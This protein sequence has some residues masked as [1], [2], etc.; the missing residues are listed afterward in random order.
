MAQVEPGDN[1]AEEQGQEHGRGLPAVHTQPI[2][3]A[4]IPDRQKA[5]GAKAA[6]SQKLLTSLHPDSIPLVSHVP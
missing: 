3:Q 6:L 4:L 2:A 1:L 5:A